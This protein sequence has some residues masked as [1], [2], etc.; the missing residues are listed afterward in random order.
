[1]AKDESK[2]KA[3][4]KAGKNEA[5]VAE[6]A[7]KPKSTLT[8]KQYEAEL[9]KLQVELIKLQAW[10]KEKGLKVVVLFEGRDAAGKGGTIKRITEKLNPRIVRVVA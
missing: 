3:K 10:I 4:N 2:S 8:K 7:N 1:M 9:Q 6:Q 5:V